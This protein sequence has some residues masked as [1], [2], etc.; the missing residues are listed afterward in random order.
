LFYCFQ[1]QLSDSLSFK[2]G[3]RRID[4]VLVVHSDN[5][6]HHDHYRETFERNLEKE[7]LELEHEPARVHKILLYFVLWLN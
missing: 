5:S 7:G 6:S 4:F 3:K 2:D 1:Q